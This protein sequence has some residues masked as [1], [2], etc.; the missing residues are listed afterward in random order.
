MDDDLAGR[1][2]RIIADIGIG[3]V[4]ADALIAADQ[5]ANDLLGML[6]ESAEHATK[7][8][9][10][11]LEASFVSLMLATHS[12][13]VLQA[14]DLPD[15]IALYVDATFALLDDIRNNAYERAAESN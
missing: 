2:A 11:L 13:R 4:D 10:Y 9:R 8:P 6:T 15:M 14:Q 1:F 12:L 7:L 3:D 5:Q